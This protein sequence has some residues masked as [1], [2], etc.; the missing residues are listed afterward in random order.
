MWPMGLLLYDDIL[1]WY[2][3][4]FLGHQSHLG[5]LLQLVFVRRRALTIEQMYF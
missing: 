2:F 3:N 4:M 5:N 1:I